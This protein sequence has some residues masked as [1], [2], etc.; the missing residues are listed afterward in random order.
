MLLSRMKIRSWMMGRT[1]QKTLV[2]RS[3][4]EAKAKEV[5]VAREARAEVSLS[6]E[7]AKV[8]QALVVEELVV[9]ELVVQEL[10]GRE[11][12]LGVAVLVVGVK[13]DKEAVGKDNVARVL[14]STTMKSTT[15]FFS[16]LLG[17]YPGQCSR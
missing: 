3:P 10:V 8:V 13:V 12:V 11:V 14:L 9:Q 4:M 1:S 6:L 7:V 17:I 15:D 5:V 2:P 16:F